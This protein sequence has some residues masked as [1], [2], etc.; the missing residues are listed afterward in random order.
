M[1]NFIKNLAFKILLR[2]PRCYVT[3]PKTHSH[4]A[5]SLKLSLSLCLVVSA[6][7]SALAHGGNDVAN[8]VGPFVI[9]WIVYRVRAGQ[10]AESKE[11]TRGPPELVQHFRL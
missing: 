7:T 6:C 4:A 3:V 2:Q 9:I 10:R 8:C 11:L 5:V 1:T